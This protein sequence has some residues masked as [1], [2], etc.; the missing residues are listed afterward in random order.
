V[1]NIEE[2]N[3]KVGEEEEQGEMEQSRQ[4]LNC[5]GKMHLVH[6][7]GKECAYSCTLLWG[8][9]RWLS[10]PDVS[11]CP[12]MQQRCQEGTGKTDDQAQKPE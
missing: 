6:A 3:D 10:K 11:T 9:P 5:P 12:L 2:K 8:T 4:C 1:V 7:I